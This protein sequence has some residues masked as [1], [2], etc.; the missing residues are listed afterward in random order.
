MRNSIEMPGV[1]S[2]NAKIKIFDQKGAP[3]WKK[4]KEVKNKKSMS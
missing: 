3:I 2:Y 1:G 4:P